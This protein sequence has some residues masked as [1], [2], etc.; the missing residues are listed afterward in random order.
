[1]KIKFKDFTLLMWFYL[2][3]SIIGFSIPWYYNFLEIQTRG[4]IFTLTDWFN[5]SMTSNL[6]KSAMFD[7]ILGITP[8]FIWM[9]LECK[10]LKMNRVFYFIL[11]S[12][13]FAFCC[14]FFL[15]QREIIL[16]INSNE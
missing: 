14:P 1:M 9:M 11:F 5:A 7:F 12:I 13:C 15:L 10:K 2:I 6:S 8:F 16:K 3:M 4:Q